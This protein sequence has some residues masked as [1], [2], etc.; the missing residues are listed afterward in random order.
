M[1]VQLFVKIASQVYDKELWL[2]YLL[3]RLDC[4]HKL[5]W[6]GAILKNFR[7]FKC[8]L[9]IFFAACEELH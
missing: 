8:I 1:L 9:P 4:G 7:E 3:P 5:R 6:F 2:L